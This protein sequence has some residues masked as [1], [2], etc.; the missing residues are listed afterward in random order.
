MRARHGSTTR[1]SAA[2]CLL[3]AAC[4]WLPHAAAAQGLTLKAEAGLGGVA[5]PG[6]WTPVR[7]V[8]QSA[9]DSVSGDLVVEW[10]GASL[11]RPVAIA[12]GATQQFEIYLQTMDVGES[13]SVRLFSG[14]LAAAS[15]TAPVRTLRADESFTACVT[16]SRGVEQPC[17]ATPAPGTLPRSPRGYDAVDHVV[18]EGGD[19][20]ALTSEQRG[21]L[22]QWR[23]LRSLEDSGHLSATDRPRS[24]MPALARKNRSGTHL[25]AGM[26]LYVVALLGA[27][28]LAASLRFRAPVA[29]ATI[30]ALIA[31][32][33]AAALA[34]G[35]TPSQSAIVIHHATLVQQLPG[36]SGS[37]VTMHGALEF[38][39]FDSFAVHALLADAA[40]EGTPAPR[41]Q[42]NP[43]LD[44]SGYPV[45]SGTFGLGDRQPFTLYGIS[46]VQPL[47]V[48]RHGTAVRVANRSQEDLAD[49]R[50]S[51][52][53]VVNGDGR[54]RPGETASADVP[55]A[56]VG[57]VITCSMAEPPVTFTAAGRRVRTAGSAALAAYLVPG[58]GAAK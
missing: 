26:G 20:A 32:G 49:C 45:I 16:G 5:K 7:I 10:G 40:F 3:A 21:A 22:A 4:L 17:A 6:R 57:P 1:A 43:A 42:S 51:G 37:V 31:A 55:G 53:A 29:L 19:E 28:L 35:R 41:V 58:A 38:P 47:S 18:W 27:G 15:A 46:D 25:R 2:A 33:T 52:G 24:I 30:A 23:A 9:A 50:F 56:G 12:A 8:L 13:V 54:L 48:V 11:R 44:E 14:G 39:A 36:V 34:A